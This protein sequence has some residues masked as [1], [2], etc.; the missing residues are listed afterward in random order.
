MIV[1]I[2]C[3]IFLVWAGCGPEKTDVL[4]S[5]VQESCDSP[6]WTTG[7][8]WIYRT[9]DNREWGYQVLGNEVYRGTK[10]YVIEGLHG[11]EKKGLDA[12][13]LQWKV[14]INPD[15][16]KVTPARPY[17]WYSYYAFPLYVGKKWVKAATGDRSDGVG[18]DY[19]FTYTVISSEVVA[20]HAG[21]FKAFKVECVQEFVKTGDK[22]TTYSW[23]SPEVK[24]E[25]KLQFS[26]AQGV[27][28][29]GG[30]GY[31]LRAFKVRRD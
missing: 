31:Q 12:K 19:L 9:E 11:A 8:A 3:C 21:S 28:Q 1:S 5:N 20:V 17:D 10:I 6:S 15:G 30:Q 16:S 29:I 25:I 24:N 2:A 13:T 26:S 23:Y 14:D 7:D 18:G 27:W 22:I 4:P